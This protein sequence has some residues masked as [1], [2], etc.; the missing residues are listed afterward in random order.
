MTLTRVTYAGWPNCFRLS[1]GH[2]E[3][4]AVADVGPRII[5]CGLVGGPNLFAELPDQ[6]GRTGG[7]EWRLYGGHR[8]WHAPEAHPR[9]YLP[10][11][12]PVEAVPLE[13]EGGAGL[14]LVQPLE[15]A[16]GLQKSIELRLEP[17][18]LR[19]THALRNCGLWAVEFA[20]WALSAM[21][22]GGVAILPLPPRGPH[23]EFLLP[24]STLTLWPYTD[25]SDARWTWGR[26]YVLLRADPA[27]ATPQKLGAL[28]PDGWVAYALGGALFVKRFSPAPSAIYPDLGSAVELYTDARMLELETLGPVARLEPG[29]TVTHV[30]RW[31]ILADVPQPASEPDVEAWVRPRVLG[32]GS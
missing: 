15:A 23:P 13:G 4:V 1:D 11:N 29:A 18:G 31:S 12:A 20:P 19:V 6:L 30:E 16:T 10:D 26:R 24:T 5:R 14:R 9:T 28:V 25:L 3:V 22:P 17:G 8:L 27:A 7:D 32:A 2:F 21:A